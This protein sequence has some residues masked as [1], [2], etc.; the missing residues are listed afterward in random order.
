[1]LSDRPPAE[2]KTVQRLRDG[3]DILTSMRCAVLLLSLGTTWRGENGESDGGRPEQPATAEESKQREMAAF[4][5][6]GIA[7]AGKVFRSRPPLVIESDY[8]LI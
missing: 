4:N 2:A 6:S 7:E 1:M 5:S 8:M 3:A